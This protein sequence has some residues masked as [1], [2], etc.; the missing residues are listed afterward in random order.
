MLLPKII[1]SGLSLIFA[2]KK[3]QR[4]IKRGFRV[5]NLNFFQ[6]KLLTV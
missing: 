1:W 6:E 5:R 4:S 2:K 3:L